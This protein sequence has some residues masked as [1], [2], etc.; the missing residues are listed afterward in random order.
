MSSDFG[1]NNCDRVM[2]WSPYHEL[3]KFYSILNQY[4]TTVKNISEILTYQTAISLSSNF[5]YNI[6]YLPS[7]MFRQLLL[8]YYNKV[9]HMF[10]YLPDNIIELVFGSSVEFIIEVS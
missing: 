4:F 7:N 9:P 1:F 6:S 3:C 10:D 5:E 2:L 8:T